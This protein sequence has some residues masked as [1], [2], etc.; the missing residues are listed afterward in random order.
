MARGNAAWSVFAGAN[1]S[2]L[3]LL[4]VALSAVACSSLAPAATAVPRRE[5]IDTISFETTEGTRL[6]FDVSP[7]GR[8]ILI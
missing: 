6:A 2:H 4:L 1:M 7:D 8:Y 3:V 5:A